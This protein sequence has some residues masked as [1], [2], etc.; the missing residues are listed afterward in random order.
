MRINPIFASVKSSVSFKKNDLAQTVPDELKFSSKPNISFSGVQEFKNMQKCMIFDVEDCILRNKTYS[1]R[2]IEEIIQQFSPKTTFKQTTPMYNQFNAPITAQT[3][4]SYWLLPS[5][6]KEDTLGIITF[7]QEVSANFPKWN[8]K[9]DKLLL[10]ARLI[11]EFTHVLSEEN[12]ASQSV[13][14]LIEKY[15][16]DRVGAKGI[17]YTL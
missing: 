1:E 12:L 4:Q 5:G 13:T 8:F 11:H 15:I 14:K 17:Q 6:K 16:K 10:A 3:K 2:E 7:P 9:K